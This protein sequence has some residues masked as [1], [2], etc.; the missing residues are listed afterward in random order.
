MDHNL[1]KC[2]VKADNIMPT[3][4]KENAHL[5]SDHASSVYIYIV[6]G[7]SKKSSKRNVC[8]S[9][10]SDLI[11]LAHAADKTYKDNI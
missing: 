7:K 1:G 10:K 8:R 4:T 2:S 11:L 9:L 5:T 6:L 3:N